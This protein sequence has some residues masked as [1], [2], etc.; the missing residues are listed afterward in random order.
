VAVGRDLPADGIRPGRSP[1]SGAAS[2]VVPPPLPPALSALT[3]TR[4]GSATLLS[5]TTD[6]PSRPTP[7]G[8]AS[9]VVAAVD[10]TG[11]RTVLATIDP[12]TV[13]EAGALVLPSTPGPVAATR[14]PPVGGTFALTVLVAATPAKVVVTAT[15]P[16]GRSAALE[17]G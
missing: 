5:L 15:D 16:L 4:N 12:A 8:P 7:A 10:P 17:E 1:A 9:L 13:P 11:S 3:V 6:L 14:R 2:V